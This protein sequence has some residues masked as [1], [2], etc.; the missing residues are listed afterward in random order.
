MG[1]ID[2]RALVLVPVLLAAAAC[3]DDETP[4]VAP[5]PSPVISA[6]PPSAEPSPS[7]SVYVEEDVDPTAAPGDLSDAAQGYL[8]EALAAELGALESAPPATA[9]TRRATLEKLPD[10]PT[11]VLAALKT[12]E[13]ISPDAKVLYGK[14]VAAG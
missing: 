10:N 12:Y 5:P 1:R 9:A 4:P 6:T 3:G 14:A 8:D 7:E 2:L 13:W 11:Q